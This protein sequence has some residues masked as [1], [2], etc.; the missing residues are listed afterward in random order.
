MGIV[1]FHN[2]VMPAVD[3]GAQ[4]A[5]ESVDALEAFKADGVTAVVATPHVEAS[6]TD[7]GG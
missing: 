3:D 1:D 6:C 5:E 4:S 7:E 2:H